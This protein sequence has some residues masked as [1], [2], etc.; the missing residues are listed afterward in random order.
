MKHVEERAVICSDWES[1][2]HSDTH[3]NN[4]SVTDSAHARLWA[5]NVLDFIILHVE[6]AEIGRGL[7]VGTEIKSYKQD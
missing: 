4:K 7:F 1:D 3:T 6:G 5:K 2:D